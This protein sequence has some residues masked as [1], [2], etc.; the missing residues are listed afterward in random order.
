MDKSQKE[1]NINGK[2]PLYMCVSNRIITGS[3]LDHM[4]FIIFVNDLE[5]II[6]SYL[7]K[8]SVNTEIRGVLNTEED[9]SLT[10]NELNCLVK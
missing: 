2:A 1:G 8:F 9:Q 10:K 7:I 3:D 6:N 4:L 5:E